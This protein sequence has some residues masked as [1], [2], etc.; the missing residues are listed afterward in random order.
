M[1]SLQSFN[2]DRLLS[3]LP[4]W[5][6]PGNSFGTP[7]SY[8][9]LHLLISRASACRRVWPKPVSDDS[10]GVAQQ[11]LRHAKSW[12][13]KPAGSW[14]HHRCPEASY[15]PDAASASPCRP[16]AV[17]LYERSMQDTDRA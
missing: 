4:S 2:V 15:C 16:A 10:I 7:N 3:I 14:S 5:L 8:R 1:A 11:N 6:H 12:K 17:C 13:A 9:R